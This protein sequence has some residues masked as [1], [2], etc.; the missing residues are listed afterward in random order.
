MLFTLTWNSDGRTI[1]FTNEATRLHLNETGRL[2]PGI[3]DT[4][5]TKRVYAIPF[6]FSH[7]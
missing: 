3:D 4:K 6:L 1:R 7:F 5:F 2:Q